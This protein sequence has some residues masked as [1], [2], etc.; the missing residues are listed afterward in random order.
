MKTHAAQPALVSP[1]ADAGEGLGVASAPLTP[2]ERRILQGLLQG[3]DGKADRR[4]RGAESPHHGHVKRIFRKYGVSSRNA[5]MA[6]WLGRPLLN[7]GLK[8][9]IS[10]RYTA[11]QARMPL[12]GLAPW[13]LACRRPDESKP[14][15]L[16]TSE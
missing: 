9:R 1:P 16:A 8:L 13:G 5:L 14:I 7:K 6:P 11:P 12:A 3:V 10:S 15:W 4:R 2:T